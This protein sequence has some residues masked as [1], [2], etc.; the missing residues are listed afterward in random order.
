MV[1]LFMASIK[2]QDDRSANSNY[3]Q[4]D[5]GT[6][7]TQTHIRMN[8]LSEIHPK[9][10]LTRADNIGNALQSENSLSTL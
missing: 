7:N 8:T 10:C 3:A 1:V 6:M 2:K 9:N 5:G 4:T